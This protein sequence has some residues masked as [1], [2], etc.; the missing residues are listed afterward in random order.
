MRQ[1]QSYTSLPAGGDASRLSP[2][3]RKLKL[4]PEDSVLV[5]NAPPAYLALLAPAPKNLHLDLKPDQSFD[6]V[7]VFVYNV[8][9][10]RALGPG[11]IR[12]VKPE[13]LLWV[14]YPKGGKSRGGTDLPSSPSWSKGDVIGDITGEKGLTPVSFVKVDEVWTAVRFKRA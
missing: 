9:E 3:A 4:K 6:A 12:A 1:L 7:Q 8:E 5:L 11:A 10:L 13:G 14:T 2:M